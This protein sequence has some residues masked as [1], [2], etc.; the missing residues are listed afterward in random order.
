MIK[1]LDEHLSPNTHLPLPITVWQV[2]DNIAPIQK[3]IK[4]QF[5]INI[6]GLI[7]IPYF[8]YVGEFSWF[9]MLLSFSYVLVMVI[10]FFGFYF[11]VYQKLTLKNNNSLPIL[12]ID[13]HNIK[14]FDNDG[15]VV[16]DKPLVS[17]QDCDFHSWASVNW[18]SISIQNK[19]YRYFIFLEPTSHYYLEVN[20][21]KYKINKDNL[22]NL[23]ESI[24][25]EV[26]KNPNRDFIEF[27]K[28]YYVN[29]Y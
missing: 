5:W 1:T 17:Y 19:I 2:F 11:K 24:V 29:G 20:D 6:A 26:K 13:N 27:N 3:Q 15:N 25:L 16:A 7:L 23:I 9:V 8:A 22:K 21:K 10:I 28:R 4:I 14:V 12:T 18:L